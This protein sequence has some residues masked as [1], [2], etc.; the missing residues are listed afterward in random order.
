MLLFQ[1][2][3]V[4]DVITFKNI[5]LALALLCFAGA[6]SST[7]PNL[8]E[9]PPPTF[10]DSEPAQEAK[11]NL[12]DVLVF[13][14][15]TG[16]RHRSIEVGVDAV[17]KLGAVNNFSVDATED[18]AWFTAENLQKYEVVVFMNTN[19]VD[20]L[21]ASQKAAFKAYIQQGGNYVG[22]HSASATAYE[23]PW[24]GQLVGA[25]FDDHPQIQ[26]AE[27]LVLD[28][29]HP[30]TAHLPAR[31]ER[32][33]E[34]YNY[35]T[36]PFGHVHVL[37]AVNEKSYEGGTMD[38]NHPIVWAH[39]FDGGRS[40]YTGLG[41]TE[42]AYQDA[43]FLQ[44]LLGG[45]SWA[46]GQAEGDV[47]A[48]LA[49]NYEKVVLMDQVTD[50]MEIAIA[51]DGRVFLAE[52]AGAVK[53]WHPETNQ[54][55]LAGWIP[56]YMVIED[57]LLG[58]TLD[59]DFM[60]NG[61]IYLYY[62]PEDAGPSRLSRFTL[63]GN[64]IDMQSEKILL[65]VPVQRKDCCHA[66]GSLTFDATGN[67]YLST[68][69]N[70]NPYD[71][72]GSPTDERPGQENADAQGSS[73]NTN[74]LRG[75]ILRIHPEEDGTYSI[76]E[77]NLF[78]GDD[79]HRPE[80]YTMGHRNPF[81]ISVDS[82]T[83]W[84]YWGDVGHGDPPNARGGWGWDEFNQAR[85]PGF[86]G[87]PYFS[88]K[89]RPW[90]EYNYTTEE[91]GAPYNAAAPI[92]DS[93]NNTGARELPP[94]QSAM[95][96]YTYGASEEFPELGAGGVNPMA[97]P[98]FRHQPTYGPTAMPAYF[99]GTH[100]IYEW[101]RN[102][103]MEVK[104]DE[105]G[106]ILK[107]SPFLK[108][109]E[110][111][112]PMD[113]EIGPEG[114]LY[115]I[116]WGESF[117]GS[118]P[119]AKVVRLEYR[120]DMPPKVATMPTVVHPT[121]VHIESPKNGSF[122]SFDSPIDYRVTITNAMGQQV[123][124]QPVSV[125]TYTGFDTH[126]IMLERQSALAGQTTITRKYTHIPDLHF[127]DRFAEIKA[128]VTNKQGFEYCD[129]VKLH[130]HQKE[131][132][133]ISWQKEAK[134]QTHGSHPA[135]DRFAQTAL[136]TMQVNAGSV[137]AYDPIDLSSVEAVTLRFKQHQ[138]GS[139]V[140]RANKADGKVLGRIDLD[141]ANIVTIEE[142]TQARDVDLALT[143]DEAI[144]VQGLNREVYEN[145]SEVAIPLTVESNAKTLVLTFESDSDKMLLE[146][147]WMMFR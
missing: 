77:G 14:K 112:R 2:M 8:M 136:T 49:K 133:H 147:D 4:P 5:F 100:I 6:C 20:V 98:V 91:I 23:W 104:F 11:N 86:F 21:D 93:P 19:G 145:W 81:R 46:A 123:K 117:W 43:D 102:W 32:N 36:N 94:A 116:E 137:L 50:P 132:E 9:L 90:N 58:I 103:V 42:E 72:E 143:H 56:V 113:M 38:H 70:T 67:L 142:T 57:G 129:K 97:G 26:T 74:D 121:K 122:F 128:C 30:S 60:D 39:E 89:N 120:K 29:L 3:S 111:I 95:I 107:I 45:I 125:S 62:A 105:Q 130:P 31:W 27:V 127:T 76:P 33:D 71:R 17:K 144:L 68:G 48:S 51:E 115:V 134:R 47:G 61:W 87:W 114:A 13:S 65:E 28:Q 108:G 124:N 16:F 138:A 118:N 66:G 22:V 24:Y 101:M 1:R 88:G 96:E 78:A 41:H 82:K 69:D 92:N 18:G 52:R 55:T 135:S 126:S 140:L 79:L 109:T 80:I 141:A 40:W 85:G 53:V 37:A 84:L 54:T 44:H 106:D 131:A 10:E 63:T 119:D 139:I 15:T 99:E 25:Y 64:Q 34:W 73:A 75:K 83:G 146:L 59:P 12:Y 7:E 110:F 35:R